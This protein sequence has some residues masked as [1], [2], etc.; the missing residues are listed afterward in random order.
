M[1]CVGVGVGLTGAAVGVGGRVGT[2]AGCRVGL[3]VG[4][5]VGADG[6]GVGVGARG[7]RTVGVSGGARVAWLENVLCAVGVVAV[8]GVVGGSALP[9]ATVQ[10]QRVRTPMRMPQ[11][12]GER[13]QGLRP[14]RGGGMG[15]GGG[16]GEGGCP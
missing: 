2:A 11:P 4:V 8:P 3:G 6:R 5:G 7:A 16:G 14:G 1:Q 10:R 13:Y 12:M 9:I 15:G